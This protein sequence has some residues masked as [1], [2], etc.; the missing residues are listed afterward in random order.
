MPIVPD[1]LVRRLNL[2]PGTPLSATSPRFSATGDG[3]TDDGESLLELSRALGS[4]GAAFFPPGTYRTS[5]SVTFSC[6]TQ[7]AL[8]ATLKPDAGV[9]VTLAGPVSPAPGA[10]VIATGTAG[11]VTI[12]GPVNSGSGVLDVR[13]FGAVGDGVTD[14][15]AAIQAAI[16]A[17]NGNGLGVLLA[18]GATYGITAFLN[19]S[20]ARLVG[21]GTAT[22]KALGTSTQTLLVR[23]TTDNSGVVGV[24]LDGNAVAR[25][26]SGGLVGSPV[27]AVVG[28]ANYCTVE[29]VIV[30]DCG[31]PGTVAGSGVLFDLAQAPTAGSV[32]H[33]AM[34][35]VRVEDA[36][37]NLEMGLRV[38]SPFDGA[39][40]DPAGPHAAYN[41]IEDCI[42]VGC[43]KHSIEIVGPNVIGTTV[44]RTVAIDPQGS[45][46]FDADFGARGTVFDTCAVQGYGGPPKVGEGNTYI[47][48][49]VGADFADPDSATLGCVDTV[50]INCRTEN[51]ALDVA[52]VEVYGV[53]V[54]GAKRTRIVNFT[55]RAVTSAQTEVWGVAVTR[56]A[57]DVLIDNPSL[58]DVSRGIVMGASLTNASRI[59]LRGGFIDASVT[60]YESRSGGVITDLMISGVSVRANDN[61]LRMQAEQT[62][63]VTGARLSYGA[64]PVSGKQL[65]QFPLTGTGVVSGTFF[66]LSGSNANATDVRA[67]G[68]NVVGCFV[69]LGNGTVAASELLFPNADDTTRGSYIGNLSE[70]RMR[71]GGFADISSGA[72]P[73]A[74]DGASWFQGDRVWNRTPAA[75]GTMGWVCTTS[76]TLGTLTG[77][78]GSITSG[79][80]ALTVNDA[81]NLRLHQ[82][83]TIA[84][85]TGQKFITA[86]A[87]TVVTVDTTADATVS[88]AAV[89][90]FA[91]VF[92]TFG[93]I[94]S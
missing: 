93:A 30:R 8:G 3:Q 94:A 12:T 51:A 65:I 28:G 18:T 33:N 60:G 2:D 78:T 70:A 59:H 43:R 7:F 83:I 25:Q 61:S 81:S 5:Q 23:L 87:G 64:S 35:R 53:A 74:P 49:R 71:N 40:Y 46:A 6:E 52:G 26:A 41:T 36:G 68:Q 20:G 50:V 90:Y 14:D 55:Q 80:T 69:R 88:G 37:G 9:T 86:I 79:Q 72:A 73:T 75:S 63:L 67:R 48:F 76:G 38:R 39:T 91:P 62:F 13:A 16:T 45:T 29:D 58:Q 10:S 77:V 47:G 57:S 24:T 22:I 17:A 4:A 85:V 92:K 1:R 66:D 54:R 19:L 44:S 42:I 34:R 32:S 21:D 84:G 89:A 82:R 31:L 27:Q 56:G 15:T 11:T